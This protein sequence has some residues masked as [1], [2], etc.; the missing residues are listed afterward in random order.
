MGREHM[1]HRGP[2]IHGILAMHD[3]HRLQYSPKSDFP[4]Q[5]TQQRGKMQSMVRL[6]IFF[7]FPK[8]FITRLLE[9]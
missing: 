2:L 4:L 7:A 8:K 3:E 1:E 6:R 5:I 9:Y